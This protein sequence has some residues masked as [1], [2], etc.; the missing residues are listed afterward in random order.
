MANYTF[1]LSF[2]IDGTQAMADHLNDFNRF[3]ATY[4]NWGGPG[5][6]G[7]ERVPENVEPDWDVVG[8]DDLDLLF[9]SHDH[10]YWN[11]TQRGQAQLISSR[12]ASHIKY[13]TPPARH[14]SRLRHRPPFSAGRAAAPRDA[15]QSP[16]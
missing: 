8:K 13:P 5:W 1:Q 11:A 6:A 14:E 15:L 9:R 12:T 3:V 4:G 7:G 16:W 10:A 2:T